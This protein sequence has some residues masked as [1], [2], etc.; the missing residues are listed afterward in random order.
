MYLI[1]ERLRIDGTGRKV[2]NMFTVIDAAT[3]E[4]VKVFAVK[5]DSN[6][7]PCFLIFD[8]TWKYKSAKSYIPVCDFTEQERECD[9]LA[10][11]IAKGDF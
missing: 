8:G 7:Y 4:L 6:G 1:Q 9:K 11:M 10:K 2:N 3:N 5:D